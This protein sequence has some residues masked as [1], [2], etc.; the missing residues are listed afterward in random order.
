MNEYAR[1]E[2]D[3]HTR[4]YGKPADEFVYTSDD[5]PVCHSRIDERGW[6]G[7]DTIGGD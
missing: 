6:C 5:C 7:C 2:A 1:D 3:F 4:L